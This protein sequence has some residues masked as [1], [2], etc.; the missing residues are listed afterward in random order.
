MSDKNK[1][2]VKETQDNKLL[3]KCEL[4]IKICEL[5]KDIDFNNM[6]GFTFEGLS[7]LERD[8]EKH[9]GASLLKN[10]SQEIS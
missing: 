4:Q 5:S 3:Y 8:L 9:G 2:K 7:N 1:I 6:W 10:N